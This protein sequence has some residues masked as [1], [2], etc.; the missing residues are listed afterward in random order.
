V[1]LNDDAGTSVLLDWAFTGEGALGEEVANLVLDSFT[2]GLMDIALLPELASRHR[3]LP[4]RPARGRLDRLGRCAP[5][6][7]LVPVELAS[8]PALAA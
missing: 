1:P 4:D 3:R 5:R 6:R 2:D 8:P 7:R